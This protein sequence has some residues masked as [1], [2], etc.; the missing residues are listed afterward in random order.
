MT[1]TPSGGL[2]INTPGV[3]I[4]NLDIK[5]MVTINAQNVTLEN[6]KIT[7][8]SWAVVN[9]LASGAT[10]KNCE[11]DGMAAE[12]IRGIS[13]GG[14]FIGNNIHNVEDGIYVNKSGTVIQD[15][16]IHDLQSN[17][18]GPH[19]DGIQIDGGVSNVTIKHNTVINDHTDTSAIMIDNYFGSTTNITIDGN[20][21]AGGGYTVYSDAQFNSGG[22]VSGVSL[23]N[24][25]LGKGHWGY[26]SFQKNSPYLSGNT[27]GVLGG[28]PD[29]TPSTPTNPTTPT[30]PTT[31]DPT[32]PDPVPSTPDTPGTVTKVIKGTNGANVLTGTSGLDKI[33]AYGGNDTL[34]GKGGND[35]LSGGTGRDTFVFD[36]KPN[37]TTNVDTITDFNPKYDT[38][39]L[40]DSVFTGLKAGALAASEFRIGT[41]ALD[42]NDHIIYNNKT[43][44]LLYDADGNGSGAAVQ[45]ATVSN[46]AKLTAADFF[47]I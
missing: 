3:T 21:L 29:S 15:N 44:A 13:G 42:A 35:I 28:T 45:F 26:Y 47:V 40:Q 33:L 11:I 9:I 41:K 7:A 8:S 25:Y 43:G 38:I 37:K 23:T 10:I 2:V 5:G 34:N 46:L 22:T 30:T 14:T 20:Y 4:K 27:E 6:C 16:Y 36:T 12:G 31:P 1:L 39:H 17:W 18:S 24:N 19:Y 32:T